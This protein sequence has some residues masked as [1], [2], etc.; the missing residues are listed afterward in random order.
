MNNST[1]L[2]SVLIITYN[3]LAFIR[4]ALDSVLEQDYSNFE[5]IV[6]DDGSTD[7][8]DDVIMEYSRE[9][10]NKIK[11]IVNVPN[12]GITG[13]SNRGLKEC[14]GK[15]V[16][17][18]GG[19]DLFLPGKLQAQ[20]D[21]LEKDLK[22]A[23]CYHDMDVFDSETNK[24]LYLQSDR[25]KFYSGSADTIIRYGTYFGATTVMVRVPSD[26]NIFFDSDIKVASDWLYWFEVVEQQ[27][28]EIGYVDGV[29]ARYRRHAGNITNLTEHALRDPLLTLDKIEAKYSNKI[30][31]TTQKRSELYFIHSYRLLKKFEIR[32][33]LKLLYLSIIASKGKFIHHSG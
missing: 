9:Y 20:V 2:V 7:G 26:R 22:R 27:K 24:T 18:I 8:T 28:G 15:Y 25:Y 19:D 5:I 13:N 12:L 21:W 3:Q 16:A 30:K 10:P 1:P 31:L 6:A 32:K 14:N 11:P 4:E 29:Y 33:S 17:F 23:L